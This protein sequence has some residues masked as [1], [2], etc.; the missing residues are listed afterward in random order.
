MGEVKG[1]DFA[2]CGQIWRMA[3][4]VKPK[5][6]QLAAFFGSRLSQIAAAVTKKE[7]PGDEHLRVQKALTEIKTYLV[8]FGAIPESLA[9]KGL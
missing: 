9:S 8:T 4:R 3:R 2:S 1:G 5:T 6:D 7:K